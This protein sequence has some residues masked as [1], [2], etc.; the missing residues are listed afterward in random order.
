MCHSRHRV[1]RS[2]PRLQVSRSLPTCALH[3]VYLLKRLLF[4]LVYLLLSQSRTHSHMSVPRMWEYILCAQL[5]P[6]REVQVPPL[7]N[8]QSC[9]CGSSSRNRSFSL[10]TVKFGQSKHDGLGH[11]D[12]ADTDLMHHRHSLSVLQ[13][14]RGPACRNPTNIIAATCGRFHAVILQ[15][16]SGHVPRI[17]DGFIWV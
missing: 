15:E 11:I 1:S 6:A 14:N 8:P 17:S 16:A 10:T 9:W 5:L 13:W 2:M 7:R 3:M 12:T 4:D